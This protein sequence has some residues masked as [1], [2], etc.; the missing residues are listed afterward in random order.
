MHFRELEYMV[1]L[2]EEQNLTRA[3]EKLFITPSA[4]I[5]QLV[6]LEKEIGTALFFRSRNGWTPTKAGEI[7]LSSAAEILNIRRE[8]Y[9]KLQ[10]IVTTQKG[11]LS[12]GF[13]PER[14]ATMFTSVYP[15]FHQKFPNITINIHEISVRQQQSMI[16]TGELDIGFMTLCKKQQTDDEYLFIKHE[17]LVLAVPKHHPV[18]QN[19]RSD[20]DRRFPVLDYTAL[21]YEPFTQMYKGSTAR[22]LIEDIFRQANFHPTVLFETARAIT[23]LEMVAAKMCCGVVPDFYARTDHPDISFYCLP[24]H[25]V[26]DI[27]ASYK[28]GSYLNQAA[29]YFIALASDYWT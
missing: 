11:F 15:A 29:R 27:V 25:P 17:E 21:C 5:Q 1:K 9:K 26:W 18:G 22:K 16:S 3:A 14:G 2:A 23:I 7:Y 12:I 13:P 10:D 24:E 20:P 6:H 19:A 4:L 28:K 8:T